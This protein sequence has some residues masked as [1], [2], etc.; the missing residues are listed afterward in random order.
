ME[1]IQW[2]EEVAR[3]R[4]HAVISAKEHLP[5]ENIFLVIFVRVCSPQYNLTS[6]FSRDTISML[7]LR[8]DLY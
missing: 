7:G 5:G 4:L 1:T 3:G 8:E 2:F 6:R